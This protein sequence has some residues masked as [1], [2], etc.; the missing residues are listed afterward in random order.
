MAGEFTIDYWTKF[1]SITNQDPRNWEHLS[2][3]AC[4]FFGVRHQYFEDGSVQFQYYPVTREYDIVGIKWRSSDKKWFNQGVA[5]ST[6]DLFGQ[7]AFRNT[8]SKTVVITAGEKDAISLYQI[9][10]E[11]FEQKGW[12]VP[13]IVSSIAGE[14]ALSQFRNHYSWFDKFDKIIICPDQ[15]EPGLEY[16]QK[17]AQVLPRNKIFVMSL[18][19]KDVNECL[20][21]G[22][23]KAVLDN[24]F[25]PKSFTP[26]GVIGSDQLEDALLE[27]LKS[28]KIP[29]P[30]FLSKLNTMTRGGFKI[31]SMINIVGPTGIGK[32]TYINELLYYWIFHSPYKM[33]ILSLELDRYEY[34][35]VIASRHHGVKL[36]LMEEYEA[37]HFLMLPENVEKRK[38]LWI[39]EEGSPRFYLMEERDGK[40]DNIKKLIEQLIIACDCRIIVLDPIQDLFAGLSIAEQEEFSAWIKIMMK[41]YQICFV[42]INHIRKSQ[43]GGIDAKYTEQEVKGSSTLIQSSA[44]NIL[45]NRE[46]DPDG[47]LSEREQLILRCTMTHRLSKNRATGITGDAGDLFYDNSSHILYDLEDYKQIN[48]ELFEDEKAT[49]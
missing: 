37:E 21:K 9:L 11:Y 32:S 46:K 43:G 2:K 17:V 27:G 26:S 39:S 13:A 42:C 8:S 48:P 5:D 20:K 28:V 44:Y 30:P 18:P 23:S 38:T 6:C 16:L 35:N 14:G 1:K 47:S 10:N 34:S 24:Y 41:A 3:K 49:Y 33:G 31:P 4:A 36:N 40:L 7:V 19:L 29:L 45:L 22:K 25:K 15:D 12:E